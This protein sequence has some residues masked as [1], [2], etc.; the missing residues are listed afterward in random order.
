MKLL[1]LADTDVCGIF[2]LILKQN[3][4]GFSRPVLLTECITDIIEISS[5]V[6]RLHLSLFQ[7]LDQHIV[8]SPLGFI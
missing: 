4:S 3:R 6:F 8:E 7:P 5:I 1:L 2:R